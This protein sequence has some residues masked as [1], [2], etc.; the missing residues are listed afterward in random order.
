MKKISNKDGFLLE[1]LTELY[2]E[3]SHNKIKK[4]LKNKAVLVNGKPISKFDYLVKKGDSISII[5]DILIQN[6]SLLPILYE[7]KDFLVI[8]KPSGLL[9]ISTDKESNLTAYHMMREYVKHKSSKNKI[10][11]LH[12]L[13]RDTSGVLVFIKNFE[14]KLKLQDKWNQLVKKRTYYA[15][16]VGK[17][18]SRSNYICY[19]KENKQQKV[20]VTNDK[21]NGKKAITSFQ[22]LKSNDKYSLLEVSIDTG[23]K[24]QIRAVLSYLGYP[25]LGD[26]KYGIKKADRLYLHAARLL[27]INPVNSKFLDFKS[28]LPLEFKKIMKHG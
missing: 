7:D 1:L 3:L 8:D 16:V 11:I 12:R 6:K 23:R 5:K 21:E 27:F 26:T 17:P 13:D 19:L 18:K 10:F 15:I 22:V 4:Y 20:Y 14:L 25:V 2:P 28:S 9:S 24:N